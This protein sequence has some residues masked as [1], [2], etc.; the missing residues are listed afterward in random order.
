[1]SI[2][3]NGRKYRKSSLLLLAGLGHIEEC[4]TKELE[5]VQGS[6]CVAKH[7]ICIKFDTKVFVLAG[8]VNFD[9]DKQ[10]VIIINKHALK[11]ALYDTPALSTVTL[12]TRERGVEKH[13][14]SNMSGISDKTR[15]ALSILE[16]TLS[17]N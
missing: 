15:Q 3:F 7:P 5:V 17:R 4:V 10:K 11:K 6:E 12:A 1:M 9:L 16:A 14:H 2:I 8:T 13:K